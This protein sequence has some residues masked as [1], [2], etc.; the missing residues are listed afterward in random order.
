MSENFYSKLTFFKDKKN[1]AC[2]SQLEMWS[3]VIFILFTLH[4]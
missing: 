4:K 1:K 2:A 3:A